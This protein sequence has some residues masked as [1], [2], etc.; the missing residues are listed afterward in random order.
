MISCEL[1]L[2]SIFGLGIRTGHYGSVVDYDV[3][4]GDGG[5]GEDGFCCGADG[6]E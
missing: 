4:F 2:I 1:Q 3:D 6:G 5:V